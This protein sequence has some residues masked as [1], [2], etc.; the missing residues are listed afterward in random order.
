M[1]KQHNAPVPKGDALEQR[2]MHTRW[3]GTGEGR[4]V[5]GQPLS[6]KDSQQVEGK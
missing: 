2:R 3:K 6:G 1:T 5:V 4:P